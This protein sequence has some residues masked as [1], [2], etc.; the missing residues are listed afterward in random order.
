M[1][2]YISVGLLLDRDLD[3]EYLQS[4][5]ADF[6]SI[7]EALRAAGLPEHQE[8]RL[9][10]KFSIPIHAPADAEPWSVRAYEFNVGMNYLC[11]LAVYLWDGQPLPPPGDPR[12]VPEVETEPLLEDYL[13]CSMGDNG[14]K[15]PRFDHLLFHWITDGFYLPMDFEE[16]IY[17]EVDLSDE[18][19]GMIGS[20]PRLKAEL[21]IL[22]Q[23]LKLPLD[24]DPDSPEIREYA[25]R[26]GK[27]K[28]WKAYGKESVACLQL[29]HASL[30]SIEYNAAIA[31]NR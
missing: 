24:Q 30:K 28:G 23:A 18:T 4:L 19:G 12:L 15:G 16:V 8:P 3:E 11:R 5:E 21:E 13:L 17:P 6:D 31:F 9:D 1:G 22:A 26:Q 29:Y 7:N 14:G 20:S 2:M 25:D 10:P 27:G